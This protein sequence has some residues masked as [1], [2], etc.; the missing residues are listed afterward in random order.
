MQKA[1]ETAAKAL[2]VVAASKALRERNDEQRRAF[3]SRIEIASMRKPT[4]PKG[5]QLSLKLQ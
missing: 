1:S 2:A 4:L 3:Y 5:L